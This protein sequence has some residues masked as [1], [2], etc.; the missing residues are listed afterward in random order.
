MAPI[1]VKEMMASLRNAHFQT[2]LHRNTVRDPLYSFN[3]D[4]YGQVAHIRR[5]LPHPELKNAL[6]S[7]DRIDNVTVRSL[8]DWRNQGTTRV[9]QASLLIR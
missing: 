5:Q 1:T 6:G 9:R 3:T 8:L 2:T 4:G 7:A